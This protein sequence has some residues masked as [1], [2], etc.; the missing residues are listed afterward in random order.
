MSFSYLALFPGQGSQAVGMGRAFTEASIRAKTFFAEADE[1][2][3]FSLSKLCFEGPL[4]ELTLTANAQPAILTVSVAAYMEKAISPKAAAGHSLGEYSALVAAGALKFADAVR[5]VNRR[6]KYMQEAVSPGVGKMIAVLGPTPEEIETAISKVSVGVKEIAN[7]NCPGQTVIAGDV[8]GVDALGAELSA[9]GAKVVPLNVS[10]PFH[11]SLMKSAADKLAV[12][13]DSV[14]INDPAFPVY[15]N[16]T[17]K[18]VTTAEEIRSALKVQVCA[19]V[20]WTESI[21]NALKDTGV[22]T[23]V[24][25]G[26][27]KVLSN[28]MKRIDPLVARI[29]VS[30]PESLKKLPD[31]GNS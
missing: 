17:A 10:A 19:S 14:E 2:L 13:L 3:G 16:A 5:L 4:E 26:A 31:K 21:L 9:I 15:A 11:C 28:L 30:D 7:L 29:E 1:A 8:I 12:D 25:Y 20:R 6:G 27:G 22:T 23:A 24:E 18:P